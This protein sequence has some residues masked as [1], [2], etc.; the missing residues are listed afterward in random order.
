MKIKKVQDVIDV[1]RG[2]KKL[3]GS[4]ISLKTDSFEEKMK[5][6]L[7]MCASYYYPETKNDYVPDFT[8]SVL[9]EKNKSKVK[10]DYKKAYNYIKKLGIDKLSWTYNHLDDG[11][12]K[13]MMIKILAYNCF[14]EPRLRFPIFYSPHLQMYDVVNS[15]AIDNEEIRLWYDII[16]LKKH[17]LS[18]LGYNITLWQNAGGAIIDFVE[19]QYK[20]KNLVEATKGDV[21]IDAGA[22]YGDTALYFSEKTKGADVYSFEF[23]PENVDIFNKNMDLNPQY[24][25]NIHL[26]EKPV[27]DVSGDKLYAVPNG[28]GTSVVSEK[29]ENAIEFETITIDDFVEQNKIQK[30]DFIKMDIEG[31]EEAALKGAVKTIKKYKPKLAICVYHKPDDLCVLP[32]LIKSMVPEYKLYLDHYTINFT[33]SVLYAKV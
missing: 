21:V 33:E 5:T 22:C 6:Y 27:S 10:Y 32:Q 29:K 24:K 31:S 16:K 23:L 7:K 11:Y 2:K 26:V 20:Y 30:V 17:N 25:N 1:I 8:Q 13:D 14:E 15:C 9:V 3:P 12:S 18:K 19:E 4:L 28:P